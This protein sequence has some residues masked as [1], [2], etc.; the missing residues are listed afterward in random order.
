MIFRKFYEYVRKRKVMTG[1]QKISAGSNH[2]NRVTEYEQKVC[3]GPG[4]H[5]LAVQNQTSGPTCMTNRCWPRSGLDGKWD[6]EDSELR[7]YA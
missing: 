2:F 7:M 1:A 4:S 3:Y 6:K 5:N